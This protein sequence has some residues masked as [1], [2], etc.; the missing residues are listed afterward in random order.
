VRWLESDGEE[1]PAMRNV[2]S[3]LSA[4]A[5]IAVIG[6]IVAAQP[7]V[8][9]PERVACATCSIELE[10]V[11]VLGDTAGP[12]GID[13]HAVEIITDSRGRYLV[14]HSRSGTI[15]VFTPAGRFVSTIGR[16]GQGPGEYEDISAVIVGPDDTLFVTD[17]RLNRISVLSPH[18]RFIRSV[19]T[20]IRPAGR[21][22]IRLP[23]GELLNASAD[24]TADRVG[25]PIHVIG[26][27]GRV[28]RSFGSRT[29]MYRPDMPL[30]ERRII[31]P[32][33]GTRV[34]VGYPIQYAIELWD[35]ASGQLLRS[36]ARKVDWFPPQLT[37]VTTP[38]SQT[39]PAPTMMAIHPDGQGRIWTIIQL[40]DRN[41]RSAIKVKPTGGAHARD[42]MEVVD[43]RRYYDTVIEVIDAAAG[44]V[45]ASRRIDDEFWFF[46]R[47]GEI[48]VP[49]FTAD[50][51]PQVE[52]WRVRLRER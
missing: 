7:H 33:G 41:W 24:R 39:P 16:R 52:I 46:L 32:A 26:P 29:G 2:K 35:A 11:T 9:V 45:L 20:E 31:A 38:L 43:R 42:D 17:A 25:L 28:T 5:G 13:D 19:R 15:K 22:T 6:G 1:E 27:D 21:N 4:V 10:R 40:P 8:D 50:G 48:M 14:S 44:H 18:H 30:L 49:V 12:G 23:S 51:V 37:P 3:V 36:M 47:N 34:W